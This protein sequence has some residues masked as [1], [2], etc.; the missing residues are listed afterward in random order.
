MLLNFSWCFSCSSVFC[1]FNYYTSQRTE[2]GRSENLSSPTVP[3]SIRLQALPVVHCP[4]CALRFSS[5]CFD[6]RVF[7]YRT[8]PWQ[9][10][11]VVS[12]KATGKIIL[13]SDTWCRSG[14][15]KADRSQYLQCYLEMIGQLVI[16]P[17]KTFVITLFQGSLLWDQLIVG[18]C[19]PTKTFSAWIT[20]TKQGKRSKLPLQPPKEGGCMLRCTLGKNLSLK[21]QGQTSKPCQG[22][23]I[24]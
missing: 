20:A 3:R 7:H 2:K 17:P 10:F 23:R 13:N 1:Q 12:Q 14:R 22:I 5:A 16:K 9:D 19:L 4:P 18:N 21:N 8:E 15:L 6:L 24:P 11:C